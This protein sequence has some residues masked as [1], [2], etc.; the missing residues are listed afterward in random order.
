MS[1]A[2]G[3]FGPGSR[4]R[5]E[6]NSILYFPLLWLY[7]WL[8]VS[9][10]SE[11]LRNG[12]DELD[13]PRAPSSQRG[14]GPTRVDWEIVFG[15]FKIR[16]WCLRRSDSATRERTPPGPSNRARTAMKWMKER[17]DCA[18]ENRS[19]TKNPEESWEK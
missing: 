9:K 18:S 19:R 1:S 5:S 16:I 11:R 8:A 17:P 10:A 7:E 15:R 14:S 12:A 13:A 3:P 4:R 2:L 6:E